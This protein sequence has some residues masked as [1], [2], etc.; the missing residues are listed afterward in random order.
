MIIIVRISRERMEK[1]TKVS[2]LSY[3]IISG[4]QK[5]KLSG[6]E[7]RAF[8]KWAGVYS[9][10]A[11]LEYDLPWYLMIAGTIPA[12]VGIVGTIIL[13]W[14]AIESHVSAADYFSFNTAFGMVMAAFS[15]AFRKKT[16]SQGL[17]APTGVYLS[18]NLTG[19][20]DP[21]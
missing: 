10:E 13:Y 1:G 4:L 16:F 8:A 18:A 6:S 3:A 12:A 20:L 7:K 5:I 21:A 14:L 15:P 9:E 17:A 2:N 11:S 19:R